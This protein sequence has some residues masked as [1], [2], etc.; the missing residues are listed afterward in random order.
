M[1]A[2]TVEIGAGV[3]AVCFRRRRRRAADGVWTGLARAGVHDAVGPVGAHGVI[4]VLGFLGTLIAL[5]RAVALD[6]WWAFVAPAL[7]VVS[8]VWLTVVCRRPVRA[9]C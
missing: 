7:A 2:A 1:T 3:D 9:E 4:M 6:A 5:E 8:V